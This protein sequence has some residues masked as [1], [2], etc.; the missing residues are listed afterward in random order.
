MRQPWAEV[1]QSA[2]RE[3]ISCRQ[4]CSLKNGNTTVV[5]ALLCTPKAAALLN[6]PQQECACVCGGGKPLTNTIA[7]SNKPLALPLMPLSG[8]QRAGVRHV[9][10]CVFACCER[11]VIGT[12]TTSTAVAEHPFPGALHPT[13]TI[14]HTPPHTPH[15]PNSTHTPHSPQPPHTP[16]STHTCVPAL[17]SVSR[18]ALSISPC[19]A[20]NVRHLPLPLPPRLSRSTQPG[21]P[22]LCRT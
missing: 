17:P 4:G 7:P 15:T 8:C 20:L 6:I 3:R 14:L 21:Y 11:T 1:L 10:V 19:P 12:H 16:N 5:G 22:V 13:H 2:N 9:P 18:P